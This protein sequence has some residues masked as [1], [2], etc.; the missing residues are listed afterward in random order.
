MSTKSS[1]FLPT[2]AALGLIALPAVSCSSLCG[3]LPLPSAHA[4]ELQ[5]GEYELEMTATEGSRRRSR[6]SGTLSLVATERQH[7]GGTNLVGH[8]DLDLSRVGAPMLRD[9]NHPS[10]DS[11]EPNA[12]GVLVLSAGFEEGYPNDAPVLAVGTVSNR[13]PVVDGTPEGEP[14][15]VMM[16]DGG[17]IALWVHRVTAEGF[18]G[19]WAEWGLVVDGRGTFCAR[20]TQR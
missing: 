6:V 7:W 11:R 3:H 14:I 16:L 9:E 20:R 18:E 13:N 4:F 5:A 15:E 19:R 12:P 2:W 10:P 8:V 1:R 17:G